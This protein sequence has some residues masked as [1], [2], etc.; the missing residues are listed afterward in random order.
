MEETPKTKCSGAVTISTTTQPQSWRF[1]KRG[2]KVKERKAASFTQKQQIILLNEYRMY[3]SKFG[4]KNEWERFHEMSELKEKYS[5]TQISEKMRRLKERFDRDRFDISDPREA[6]ILELCRSLWGAG[7]AE[8]REAGKGSVGEPNPQ[9]LP[10]LF[11]DGN[12]PEILRR[13]WGL[14]GREAALRF[15]R[16]WTA[17]S[18]KEVGLSIQKL[19]LKAQ[20]S[21]ELSKI[22]KHRSGDDEQA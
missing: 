5:R 21:E 22:I 19:I 4:N 13:N 10:A 14:M 7:D 18:E 3:R 12:V 6:R 17:L 20:V 9:D 1:K 11:G 15:E 8:Q 16:R 2:L